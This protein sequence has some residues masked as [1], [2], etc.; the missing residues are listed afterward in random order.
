MMNGLQ[1]CDCTAEEGAEQ[2][3]VDEALAQLPIDINAAASLP[4]PIIFVPSKQYLPLSG[5][6]FDPV[7][8]LVSAPVPMSTPDSD[9]V[10]ATCARLS[11]Q[12]ILAPEGQ[13]YHDSL[14]ALEENAALGCRLCTF[15]MNVACIGTLSDESDLRRKPGPLLL[16][17]KRGALRMNV[18]NNPLHWSYRLSL[19]ADIGI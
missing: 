18:L 3:L 7:F 10:C 6:V 4:F 15:F 8:E 19:P 9:I 11:Y 1:G 5:F 2:Q 12:Q 14:K 13:I 17:M 16:S